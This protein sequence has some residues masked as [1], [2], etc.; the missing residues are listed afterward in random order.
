MISLITLVLLL[1]AHLPSIPLPIS[2]RAHHLLPITVSVFS[3]LDL[4]AAVQALLTPIRALAGGVTGASL[5]SVSVAAFVFPK[6]LVAAHHRI[7]A[8]PGCCCV[9]E[10]GALVSGPVVIAPA[11][12]PEAIAFAIIYIPAQT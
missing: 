6:R 11:E 12:Q 2:C 7:C 10:F 3:L 1:D 9:C 4:A 5:G 8:L